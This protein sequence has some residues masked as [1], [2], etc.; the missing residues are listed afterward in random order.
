MV[1]S[2]VLLTVLFIAIIYA[3]IPPD[4]LTRS[5]MIG[6]AIRIREYVKTNERLPD[7]V[8]QLPKREG[9]SNSTKDGWGN[10]IKYTVDA[11]G[12]VT[13]ASFGKDGKPG[14]QRRNA[15]IVES[16]DP[17]IENDYPF[18]HSLA[19]PNDA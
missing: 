7:Y 1:V 11:N 4:D 12:I 17:R 6:I 9:Y 14:G 13:L 18:V 10:E 5:N 16:F 15:D 19:A 2:V 8:Y 3:R